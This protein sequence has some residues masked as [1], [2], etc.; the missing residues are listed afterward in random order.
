MT[1]DLLSPDGISGLTMEEST[2]ARGGDDYDVI[3]QRLDNFKK[4][5]DPH[6]SRITFGE[7]DTT[8]IISKAMVT[9]HTMISRR[10]K[11]ALLIEED[12]YPNMEDFI[13][14]F[15][16]PFSKV[17]G[18]FLE[19]LEIDYLTYL[20]W[21]STIFILQAYRM[22]YTLLSHGDGVIDRNI[23][24]VSNAKSSSFNNT[25]YALTSFFYFYYRM[26]V[27]IIINGLPYGIE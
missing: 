18:L 6:K 20:K 16:G 14:F 10:V 19:Q 15:F 7:D 13:K 9:E 8:K 3:P 17:T 24:L 21:L 25:I 11:Q 23:L 1:A 4:V 26:N 5:T 27:L 2:Y 22:S 12:E